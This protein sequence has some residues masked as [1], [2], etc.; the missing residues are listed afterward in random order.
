MPRILLATLGSLGDL[1][2][3]VAI[4]QALRE[5]GLAVRL[6]SSV[7]YRSRIEAAG[8]EYAVLA[9]SLDALG[10]RGRLARRFF[11]RHF[12]PRRLFR[13]MVVEPL[14]EAR[15][16]LEAALHGVD[17]VVSHP[18]TPLLPALAELRGL[19]WLSTA[20]APFSLFSLADPPVL[21]NLPWLA[22][23]PRIGHWPQSSAFALARFV[24][25]RWEAPV[26]ALRRE[27][28]LPP[29]RG[30]LLLDGQFSPFATLALF[31]GLLAPPQPDWPANTVL[32]GTPLHDS[33]DPA[34]T[35]ADDSARLERFLA[36][37][38]PPVVFALG[39]SAVWI[40]QD[41]WRHAVAACETLG[42]RGLLLTGPPTGLHLPAAVQAFEYLPY[43]RVFPRA[44]A[45]VH[46][47][48]IGTLSQALRAGRP[49]LVV[50]AG[51]DQPDNASRAVRLGVAASLPFARVRTGPLTHALGRL[52]DD[53]K[54][55]ARAVEVARQLQGHDGAARA[56]DAIQ[57]LLPKPR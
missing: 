19:P 40:A 5:R 49:Q 30:A 11:H 22:R 46:Q 34:T 25:R 47:G 17:L 54:R 4:G 26:H 38:P 20:L 36:E 32:C 33:G 37:G 53:P 27:L 43:S 23:L 57:R 21:P 41:F 44:A 45:I 6:A 14:A 15:R 42:R 56:A 8:L 3:F 9:P 28:G 2:P 52:L 18:L 51:F 12:G 39:S 31:D 16:D 29:R 55:S 13:Q 7:E 1:H 24:A 48:G 50:P 35:D 10:D